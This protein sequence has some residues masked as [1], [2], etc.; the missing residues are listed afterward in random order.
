[1]TALRDSHQCPGAVP[2]CSIP[3]RVVGRFLCLG[4]WVTAAWAYAGT[5]PSSVAAIYGNTGLWKVLTSQT[6]S[7]GQSSFSLWCDRINRNPGRLTVSTFGFSGSWGITR[8]LEFGAN[9]E[10]YRHVLVGRAEELSF[11]QQ[12]LGFFGSKKPGSPPHPAELVAGSSQVPQLRFPPIPNGALSG[13]AGYYNLLPFAGLVGSGGA[14]GMLSLGG[15]YRI[16]SESDG[17][18]LG[19]AVHAYFGVPIHKSIDY[20]KTHPI[21]TADLQFGFFG[22]VSRSISDIAEL[23]WDFGYRRI[24]QPAHVSVFRLAEV[25]P[26][27]FGFTIP[28]AARIQFVG[29]STA[30]LFFGSHTPNT[31]F[32]AEDPVD[33][34]LGFRAQFAGGFVL[35]GGYRRPLNQFGGDKNGFVLSVACS[36]L[37]SQS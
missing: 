26:L 8:R 4:L 35:S 29:E 18:F 31:S 7:P 36:C 6:L 30:E 17:A 34:T 16:L 27:G 20:L 24:N 19:L 11:G 1:M 21:G 10:A 23:T 5:D 2:Q 14:A 3:M 12:A 9:L 37:R 13:A 25:L 22:I 28:K 15:K 33:L 32:G